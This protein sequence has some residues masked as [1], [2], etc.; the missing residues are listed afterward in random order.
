MNVAKRLSGK[1]AVVTA[2]T[3]GIGFAI[4]RRLAVE[5]AKVVVS[6]RKPEKVARSV[7]E[8]KKEN[9]EVTG[10]PCHVGKKDE[11]ENLIKKAVEI[12]GKINI[13]V[14]N[15]AVNP[16]FGPILQAPDEAWDKIFDINVKAAA[17]LTRLAAP[18]IE[19]AGGGSIIYVSSLAGLVPFD[20]SH[21]F[22]FIINSSCPSAKQVSG[23]RSTFFCW[24]RARLWSEPQKISTFGAWSCHSS[25][26]DVILVHDSWADSTVITSNDVATYPTY[27]SDDTCL[28]L[29]GGI[30]SYNSLA[31]GRQ[32]CW[33]N[34]NVTVALL[35]WSI[36]SQQDSPSWF[37]K[38]S[39]KGNGR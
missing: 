6:S 23:A 20:V 13:L 15:A 24:R 27:V 1:V 33:R 10:V 35:S 12:Y 37:D 16:V 19:A 11:R 9:L 28:N 14:S 34:D 31:V 7:E 18:H 22:T 26:V 36:L 17:S 21:P 5:G 25:S 30:P 2:S 8:L 32:S 29:F 38:G 3:E 4:A 39:G